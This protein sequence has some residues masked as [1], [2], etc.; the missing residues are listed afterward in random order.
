MEPK[1]IM[2]ESIGKRKIDSILL[3]EPVFNPVTLDMLHGKGDLV[4]LADIR[5]L[6]TVHTIDYVI[7][8]KLLRNTIIA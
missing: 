5:A 7:G 1:K 6:Q 8:V 2:L 3:I 4:F